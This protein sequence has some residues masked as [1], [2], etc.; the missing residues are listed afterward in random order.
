MQTSPTMAPV[1]NISKEDPTSVE[2][3]E[4]LS[5]FVTDVKKRYDSLPADVGTLDPDLVSDPRGTFLIARL[6]GTAVGCGALVPVDETTAELKR[7][8][9][10]PLQRGH[11]IATRILENLENFARECDYDIIRLETGV[12]QPES[13][14]LYGKAGFYRIPNFAPFEEDVT[15]VCFEKRI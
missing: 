5:A 1:I 10:N 6:G 14:A 4:L 13:I 15:A 8:Y 12:K 7:M 9:V 2:A 11:G 3:Q